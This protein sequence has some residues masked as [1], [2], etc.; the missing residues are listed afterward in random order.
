MVVSF[1]EV[2]KAALALPEESRSLL[3]NRL[4]E[5]LSPDIDPELER[6]HLEELEHRDA[7]LKSGKI[8]TIPRDEA[9][10]RLRRALGL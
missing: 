7:E 6:I 10:E 8:R 1:E 5:S 4:I 3:V 2:C 9:R